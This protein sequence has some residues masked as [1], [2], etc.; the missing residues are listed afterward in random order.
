VLDGNSDINP[1]VLVNAD[2]NGLL[3]CQVIN[4][5]AS[6]IVSTIVFYYYSYQ[7]IPRIPRGYLPRHYK[8]YKNTS[9]A[10]SRRNITGCKIV[11]CPEGCPDGVSPTDTTSPVQ[12]TLSNNTGVVVN[13]PIPQTG[14]TPNPIGGV[15]QFGGSGPLDA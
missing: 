4:T 5:T 13:N 12:I 3:Q 1:Y 10:Q 11:Y 14:Q 9:V 6:D 15:V 8:F 7:P 2:S